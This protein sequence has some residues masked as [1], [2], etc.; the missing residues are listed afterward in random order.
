M[1]KY[2]CR[3]IMVLSLAEIT[4]HIV[5]HYL[6]I[7]SAIDMTL[8]VTIIPYRSCVFITIPQSFVGVN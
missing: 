2:R 4:V 7:I 3:P 5:S 6:K 8:M 1:F